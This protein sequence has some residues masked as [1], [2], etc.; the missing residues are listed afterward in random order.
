MRGLIEFSHE[1]GLVQEL[2]AAKAQASAAGQAAIEG[3]RGCAGPSAGKLALLHRLRTAARLCPFASLALGCLLE[4]ACGSHRPW[5]RRLSTIL[6]GDVVKLSQRRLSSRQN[7]PVDRYGLAL[8]TVAVEALRLLAMQALDT[9]DRHS[10][11]EYL[12]VAEKIIPSGHS[13]YEEF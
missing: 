9:S 2:D 8:R 3:L 11:A 13:P 10:A 7:R 5:R 1:I 4:A 12:A 6:Y